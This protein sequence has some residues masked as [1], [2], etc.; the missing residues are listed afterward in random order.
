MRFY[1]ADL[2]HTAQGISAPTFPLGI[3]Y[4]ASSI[5]ERLGEDCSIKLFKFPDQLTESILHERPDVLFMSN[6]TWNSQLAYAIA[7]R[8]KISWP[9]VVVVVGGP[10]FPSD[11]TEQFNFLAKRPSIDFFVQFEGELGANAVLDR[12]IEN[13]FDSLKSKASKV[14]IVNTAY[15]ADGELIV[16]NESRITDVNSIPSP[17]LSGL[18]D[19]FFEMPIIPMMETTRG[20]PF[21]C[22]FC[23]DGLQIKSRV[24]RFGQDRIN[25][26]LSYVASR[27]NNIEELIITDLNFGMYLN[28]IKTAEKIAALQSEYGWPKTISA[29]AG[30]NKSERIIEVA[31]ILDGSWTTGASIQ[32]TD[33]DVLV[34]VRRSNISRDSYKELIDFGNSL[35]NSKTHSEVI[36]GLPSDSKDKHFESLR[37][38]IDNQVT[39]LRMFQAMLLMGTEMA[40]TSTREK[41][42][43]ETRFRTIAGCVGVYDLFGDPVPIAEIEEIIV[44]SN[45]L[46]FSDYLECRRMNLIIETFYN[47]AIFDEVYGLVVA[48]GGSYFDLLLSILESPEKFSERVSLIFEE[49]TTQTSEDLYVTLSDAENIVL[50]QEIIDMHVGGELGINELLVCRGELLMLFSETCELL[51]NATS[52]YLES[53]GLLTPNVSEYLLELKAFVLMRKEGVISRVWKEYEGDFSF[54][55]LDISKQGFKIDPNNLSRFDKPIR[56]KFSQSDAQKSHISNQFR[57]YE[58]TPNGISRLIQRSNLKLF[59]RTFVEVV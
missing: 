12:L 20:C 36:L 44:G 52:D 4:V 56:L 59:F 31:T 13:D 28:D 10:N 6:Y 43:F 45:T 23:A 42:A 16:G 38:G 25:S 39:H 5:R 26:E 30:K 15:M 51:F 40:E 24:T 11:R 54:D 49:F 53:C 57:V 21:T 47:Q 18:L 46:P 7:E 37:F 33:P 1:F 55:F 29:S 50:T 58:S 9:Q 48:L 34:A 35:E 17:Y 8:T 2:T 22:T 32:S 41:Y 14:E 27:V 3:A 19:P